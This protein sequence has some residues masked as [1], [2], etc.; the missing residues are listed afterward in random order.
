VSTAAPPDIRV[1][2]LLD[3]DQ[4]SLAEA[5]RAGLLGERRELPPRCLYDERGSELFD[6]ITELPEYYPARAGHRVEQGAGL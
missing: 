2:V 3:S 4:G 6:R 5:V 1:E